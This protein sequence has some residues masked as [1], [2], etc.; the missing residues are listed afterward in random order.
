VPQM[1]LDPMI[2]L[3]H[4]GSVHAH[5]VACRDG[6]GRGAWERFTLRLWGIRSNARV[7]IKCM[8]SSG[9]HPPNLCLHPFFNAL[10]PSSTRKFP[11]PDHWACPPPSPPN[12][13]H[14][15]RGVAEAGLLSARS[16][17]C[18]WR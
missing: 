10:R 8:P 12:F 6:G 15:T 18:A 5:A 3:L 7:S 14:L 9:L 2:V 16:C 11:K 17:S 4:R 13:Q 1:A